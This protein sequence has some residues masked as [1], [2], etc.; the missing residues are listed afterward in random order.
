MTGNESVFNEPLPEGH[1]L[2]LRAGVHLS[3]AVDKGAGRLQPAG[4]RSARPVA[5]MLF[6][7]N[8]SNTWLTSTFFLQ[9]AAH[10]KQYGTNW[11]A[12]VHLQGRAMPRPEWSPLPI[13]RAS[14]PHV[15]ACGHARGKTRAGWRLMRPTHGSWPS[16][17]RHCRSRPPRRPRW[18]LSTLAE[19]C[20]YSDLV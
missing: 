9:A 7:C 15:R 14:T 3:Q 11:P 16:S 19:S 10:I 2:S 13:G 12:A 1:A 20:L 5:G 17:P 4:P 6:I 8:T 18:T